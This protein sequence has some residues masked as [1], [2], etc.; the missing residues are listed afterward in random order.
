MGDPEHGREHVAL[1]GIGPVHERRNTQ[2]KSCLQKCGSGSLRENSL[3]SSRD[4]A[5]NTSDVKRRG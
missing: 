2:P 5:G 1:F 3:R 4:D